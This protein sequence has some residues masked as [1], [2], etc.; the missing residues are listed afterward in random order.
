M[1]DVRDPR[2]RP[3]ILELAQESE[4][5]VPTCSGAY[6]PAGIA[7]RTGKGMDHGGF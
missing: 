6:V 2:V 4:I 7:F 1:A 3:R 5:L